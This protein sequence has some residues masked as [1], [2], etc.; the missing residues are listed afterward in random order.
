MPFIQSEW[1]TSM[2]SALTQ[3]NRNRGFGPIIQGNSNMLKFSYNEDSDKTDFPQ[4]MAQHNSLICIASRLCLSLKLPGIYHATSHGAIYVFDI[5]D[6]HDHEIAGKERIGRPLM[7]FLLEVPGF[8]WIEIDQN[9]CSVTI[10][11]EHK[12]ASFNEERAAS[13]AACES[14]ESELGLSL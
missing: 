7:E 5:S 6:M 9:D 11:L 4:T 14:I 10:G 12:Y 2:K 13:R 1:F 8:R 3:L